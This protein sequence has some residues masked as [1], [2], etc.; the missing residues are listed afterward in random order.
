[1]C[2]LV[3]ICAYLSLYINLSLALHLLICLSTRLLHFLFHFSFKLTNET[4]I[5]VASSIFKL[6][7]KSSEVTKIYLLSFLEI[8]YLS[9][10]RKK[11][12][13]AKHLTFYR[14]EMFITFLNKILSVTVL[15]IIL[16][17]GFDGI[18]LLNIIQS[19]KSKRE[20]LK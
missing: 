20:E 10:Y 12:H 8:D 11:A 4:A 15:K 2:A 16:F 3:S 13:S 5:N 6:H 9:I 14:K 7:F 19:R 1:M 17:L 18:G